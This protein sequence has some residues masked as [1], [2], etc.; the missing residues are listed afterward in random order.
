MTQ[1]MIILHDDRPVNVRLAEN[2]QAVKFAVQHRHNTAPEGFY[3][4]ALDGTEI[5]AHS[6]WLE[7]DRAGELMI[8]YWLDPWPGKDEKPDY[9]PLVRVETLKAY[10]TKIIPSKVQEV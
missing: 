5:S 8:G 4:R 2:L 7:A 9:V 1:L 6:V 10:W 3:I